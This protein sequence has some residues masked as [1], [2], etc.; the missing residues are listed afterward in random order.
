L[1]QQL[2]LRSEE[3]IMATETSET[4]AVPASVGDI[5]MGNSTSDGAKTDQGEVV[6]ET[7]TETGDDE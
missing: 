3:K 6:T 1:V 7:V 5:I 2:K 4:H